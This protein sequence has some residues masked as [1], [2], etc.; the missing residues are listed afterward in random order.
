MAAGSIIDRAGA[1]ALIPEQVANT[2]I[3][4]ATSASTALATFPQTRM[5]SKQE[6]LP[7]L[8][9]LPS[10]Y[11]VN[12]DT[13]LKTVDNQA[14]D[15]LY[16]VAEPL[17]VIVPIPEDVLDDSAFDIWGEVRPRLVEAFGAA[18]DGAVF[19]GTNKPAS[20]GDDVLSVAT[21]AGNTVALG[22]GADVAADVAAV[23]DEVE[24]DGYEVNAF[25]ARR[26]FRGKLRGL[27]ASTG[28]VI[29]GS[30]LQAD[31][32]STL[33]G[34]DIRYMG[35]GAWD[36]AAA[37]LFALDRTA[38]LI[39]IRKDITYKVLT[40]AAITDATGKVLYNLAQQDMIALRAVMRL[41]WQSAAPLT[42]ENA[43]QTAGSFAPFGVLTP[44]TGGAAA[45][46]SS[47]KSSAS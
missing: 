46:R 42:R 31:T 41:G 5:S 10:A 30:S 47:S 17:A 23:M 21:A 18:I 15:K 9:A 40:E 8:S 1:D 11:F 27:R 26:A 25:V 12:G 3:Q 32:P 35:N 37:E 43:G 20:W 45:S 7:V 6:R 14:W 24:A 34:V 22:T 29:Y 13:G 4:G 44:G 19:F 39:G 36:A 38:G 33:Y 16:L 2:I 28:E